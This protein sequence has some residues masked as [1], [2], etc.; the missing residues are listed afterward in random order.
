MISVSRPGRNVVTP[1]PTNAVITA[2]TVKTPRTRVPNVTSAAR[3]S[4]VLPEVCWRNHPKP[5]WDDFED[6]G[7][8]FGDL[9]VE[10]HIHR[11]GRPNLQ[12]RNLEGANATD[13]ATH[14]YGRV[15]RRTDQAPDWQVFDHDD[16]EGPIVRTRAGDS[17]AEETAK[18]GRVDHSEVHQIRLLP[19]VFPLHLTAK[20]RALPECQRHRHRV[21][22]APETRT[23]IGSS[24]E[25]SEA[26]VQSHGRCVDEMTG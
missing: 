6:P 22:E 8:F 2:R 9:A 3:L 7:G 10:R 1:N 20:N 21:R 17:Q 14:A 5:C 12:P 15:D 13:A 16:V 11:V 4:M 24:R 19:P 26:N 18:N 25:A 23:H